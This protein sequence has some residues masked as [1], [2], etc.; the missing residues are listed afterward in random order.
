MKIKKFVWLVLVIGL[1][2][3]QAAQG[4]TPQP[5]P[6]PSQSPAPKSLTAAE[7]LAAIDTSLATTCGQETPKISQAR[8]HNAQV[9]SKQRIETTLTGV[10][11]GRVSGNYGSE[12]LGPDGFVN[13]DYYMLIDAQRGEA[14]V[15]EQFGSTRAAPAPKPGAPTW[16]YV[17]CGRENY[18][19]R[20]PAQVHTF[21]KVADNLI[22]ARAI[23][24]TSTGQTFPGTGPLVLADAW[25]QLVD[26]K[27]FDDPA[28]SLAYAGGFFKPFSIQNVPVSGGSMLEM[29]MQAEYRGSGETAVKFQPGVP[30]RGYERGR[31]LGVSTSSQSVAIRRAHRSLRP[32]DGFGDFLVSS[33]S[34]GGLVEVVKIIE[35]I[36][37][38]S[39]PIM[40]MTYDKVVIGPLAPMQSVPQMAGKS[41]NSPSGSKSNAS[42]RG[43]L[44][45]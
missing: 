13:V 33:F 11:H 17:S 19:P 5:N 34:L 41:K 4:A 30:M 31:F 40:S 21:N 32:A 8:A 36:F 10:W 29:D 35:D 20:H 23:L 27:Y 18:V 26:T 12:Y 7:S 28:R 45:R 22:D 44:K 16:S 37:L 43:K 24:Q 3:I 15:F 2:G 38:N 1:T 9:F 14:L 42:V 39:I 6:S 25:K